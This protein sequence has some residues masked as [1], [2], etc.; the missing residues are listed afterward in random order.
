MRN[1][2]NKA[3]LGTNLRYA[4]VC[5]RAQRLRVK[6]SPVYLDWKSVDRLHEIMNSHK[7]YS[8]FFTLFN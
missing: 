8:S 3:L 6:A 5:P 4:S 1:R 7:I 2:D